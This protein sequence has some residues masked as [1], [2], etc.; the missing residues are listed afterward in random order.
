MREVSD[1]GRGFRA[2]PS[3][4]VVAQTIAR[5]APEVPARMAVRAAQAEIETVRAAVSRGDAAA[6]PDAIAE[7]GA[8]R[9]RLVLADAPGPVINATGVIIHTNLGR[10]PLSERALA[11]VRAAAGGYSDLEFDL[12]TGR[13]GSRSSHIS[14]VVREVTGAGAALVLNNNAAAVFL[15]LEAHARGR[16]VL[17][18]RGESI[19]IGGGFR[20]PDILQASGARLRDVGTTNRTRVED[21]A[22]AVTDATAAIMRVHPSNFAQVGFTESPDA[23]A[24]AGLARE[25]GLLLITD[26]GSG[27]LLDT[28]AYG[29]AREPLIGEALEDG[30]DLVTFSGDKLLGGPQ[31]GVIVGSADVVERIARRPMARALRPDKMTI[32]GLR[33]T[34][35]HYLRGEAVE[36][37]P[38][39]QMIACGLDELRSRAERVMDGGTGLRVVDS[40]AAV[41]GGSL[42]GQVLPSVAIEIAD[43]EAGAED[44]ARRLRRFARPVVGRIRADRLRLDMRT[45]LPRDEGPLREALQA[46]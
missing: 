9:A 23:R 31:A 16:E 19:E 1:A 13:R 24:L 7:A 30:A 41:G 29:L 8:L 5:L 36:E 20:I 25:C 15:A 45:V 42:P 3:V 37:V 18:A 27:A 4:D 39:W 44:A 11:A 43:A 12:T 6:A 32:A 22:R 10:A 21:Y 34:L 33:A 40:S 2:I 35:G 46:L 14:D 26:L 38:V 17:V 28:A